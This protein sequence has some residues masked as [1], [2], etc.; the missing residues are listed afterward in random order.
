MNRAHFPSLVGL[1][2]RA[3]GA[4]PPSEIY[5]IALSA[6]MCVSLYL[7]LMMSGKETDDPLLRQIGS[8]GKW[9]LVTFVVLSLFSE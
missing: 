7:Q 4:Q 6:D 3:F 2:L 8:I 5:C 1:R 9:Q